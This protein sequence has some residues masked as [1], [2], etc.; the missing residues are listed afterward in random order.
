M[1]RTIIANFETRREAETAVEHLVQEHGVKRTDI[2]I[3]AS[4]EANTAGTRAAGADVESGHPGVQ[5]RGTPEL[6]GAIE[7]AVDCHGEDTTVVES[8]LRGAG[9]RQLRS[10]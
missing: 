1:E 2:F 5:K 7:V 4:G 9:A 3:R 10:H 8:T 6:A